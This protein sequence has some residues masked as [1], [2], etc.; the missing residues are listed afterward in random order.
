M[1]LYITGDV[2]D[3]PVNPDGAG[4]NAL[5]AHHLPPLLQQHCVQCLSC[6]PLVQVGKKMKDD[7]RKIMR[8]TCIYVDT[9]TSR[10]MGTLQQMVF[11]AAFLC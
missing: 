2:P 6:L 7:S 8:L 9:R 1:N 4:G 10:D 5:Q 3:M 11:F